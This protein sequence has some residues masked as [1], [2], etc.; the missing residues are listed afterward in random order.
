MLADRPEAAGFYR[1]RSHWHETAAPCA[2]EPPL[3]GHMRVDVCVLGGGV[4]GLSTA[5]HLA[6]AS[7]GTRVA[8]LEA[9]VA[10]YGASGRNAGQLLVTFG[11]GDLGAQV[12]R[13]GAEKVGQA[14]TYVNE[15]IEA[16]KSV[17]ATEGFDYDFRETGYLKAALRVEGDAEIERYQRIF[18]Q[19]GHGGHL[20]YLNPS[21]VEEE[22]HSP[23]IG[24]ALY[25]PRGGQFNP[26]K[27]VRG[28]RAAALRRG[29]QLFEN[30]PV[31]TIGTDGPRVRVETGQGAL[32]ADRL[33]LA[34]N[35]YTHLLGGA[36]ALGLTRAQYPLIVRGTITEPL[37]E[38]DWQAAGWPR[39][40]GVNIL[41]Q[42]FFSFAPTAQGGMLWVGGYNTHA[43]SDRAL[44][45]EVHAPLRSSK[46][47]GTFFPRLAHLKTAQTW[48]GPI[49][50]TADWTPHLGVA[51]DPRILYACGCWGHGMAIGFRNG[52][53]LAELALSPDGEASR[54]WLF[55][56]AKRRWPPFLLSSA[57][58]RKVI[59]DRRRGNR[60]IAAKMTP[61]LDLDA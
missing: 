36:Q 11:G 2:P 57:V 39:R 44:M 38:A 28:L 23:L 8:L 61:R 3:R 30:S 16:M 33:V 48:G 35:A 17:A 9:E 25:D 20:H 52:R 32:E 47:V 31:A 50:I 56:R 54:L 5:Y 60:R 12:R 55:A 7:S 13:H 27:L 4:T 41:S 42:L 49:S 51:R 15:G 53:T 24:G 21:Q 34:T 46:V 45:P 40:S 43:P 14:L 19:V 1:S 59:Y 22:L 37:S 29:V 10:G 58:A 6:C 26:L 18:E